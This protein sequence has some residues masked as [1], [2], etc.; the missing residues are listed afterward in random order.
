MD[1]RHNNHKKNRLSIGFISGII[2]AILATGSIVTWWSINTLKTS[3][4]STKNSTESPIIKDNIKIELGE[5]Y[6]LNDKGDRFELSAS[7][8]IVEKSSNNQEILKTAL[9]SLL[10]GSTK[11]KQI[12]TIP[13]GTELLNLTVDKE[14][15]KV[16]L[17]REFITGGG[18]ASMTGRLAQILYTATSLDPNTKVWLTIDGRPLEV[19]GEEGLEIEQ[20]ITRQW[21]NENFEL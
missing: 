8:V 5:V 13:Q 19:L 1:N 11:L 20:P 16:D 17:S 7:P 15:V 9:E 6:W 12:T 2:V 18:S 21:F 3:N 4:D 14:G 10:A